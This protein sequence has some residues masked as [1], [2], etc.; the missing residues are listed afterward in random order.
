MTSEHTEHVVE[1]STRMLEELWE[2]VDASVISERDQLAIGTAVTKAAV[3]GFLREAA[4]LAAGAGIAL[5]LADPG[6]G[7]VIIPD[8]WR[9]QYGSDGGV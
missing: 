6:G 3:F 8:P 1:I 4:N 2:R 9:D 5:T 7:D